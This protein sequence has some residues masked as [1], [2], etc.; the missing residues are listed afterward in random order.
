MSKNDKISKKYDH[1]KKDMRNL[2]KEMKNDILEYKTLWEIY[3]VKKNSF[4]ISDSKSKPKAFAYYEKDHS[5]LIK[6]IK[7]L[8][9]SGLLVD[10]NSPG[11]QKFKYTSVFKKLLLDDDKI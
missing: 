11:S 2:F 10:C 6:K 5:D 9:H 7:T 3:I 1:F 8:V 4:I